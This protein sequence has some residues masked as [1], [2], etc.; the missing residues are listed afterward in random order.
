MSWVPALI[1]NGESGFDKPRYR[2]MLSEGQK[3]KNSYS[4]AALTSKTHA[5]RLGGLLEQSCLRIAIRSGVLHLCS[6]EKEEG[7]SQ[8]PKYK[9]KK[10][11]GEFPS[12]R[13]G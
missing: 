1:V 13:S 7:F 12:W 9:K 2:M 10:K 3:R 11:K 4:R 8:K 5:C 6:K